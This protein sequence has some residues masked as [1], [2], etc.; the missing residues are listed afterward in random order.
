M[1]AESPSLV[2]CTVSKVELTSARFMAVGRILDME[3]QNANEQ[4]QQ[5]EG[6]DG[7]P[8]GTD[9]EDGQATP[10]NKR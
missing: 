6:A 1:S 2:T 9:G 4:M 3:L 8:G 10:T 7:E 5:L